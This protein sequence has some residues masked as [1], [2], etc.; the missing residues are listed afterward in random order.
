MKTRKNYSGQA[1]AII[2]VVLVVATVIGASL[3]SR[4]LKNRDAVTETKESSRA[5]EQADSILDLIVSSDLGL[6]QGQFESCLAAGSC[7]FTSLS[8]FQQSVPAIDSGLANQIT[9]LCEYSLEDKDSAINIKVEY[10]GIEDY[11]EW[12]VGSVMAIRVGGLGISSVCNMTLGFK[13]ADDV[14]QLFT[15]KRVYANSDGTVK[16]YEENDMLLY[17]YATDGVCSAPVAPSTSIVNTF[18]PSNSTLQIDMGSSSGGYSLYEIRVLP[19]YGKL[20]VSVAVDEC[21]ALSLHNYKVTATVNCKGDERA[22]E[23][24]IPN[25]SNLGYPALFDYTIYNATG[26]LKPN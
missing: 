18:S 17:C 2:M 14:D 3:Y 20:G 19:L 9:D 10:A 23:V 13:S 8:G 1:I 16:P 11:K 12:N 25:V 6:V 4:M 21:A 22:M 15:V 24:I 5:L 7:E 26:I